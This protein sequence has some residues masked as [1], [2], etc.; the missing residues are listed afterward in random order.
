VNGVR[1]RPRDDHIDESVLQATRDH[2]AR[3][4]YEAMSVVAIAADAGTTRQAVYRRWPSKAELAAAAVASLADDQ[5]AP[6]TDDPFTDLVAE[7]ASFALG[8]SRPGGLSMIGT[9]LQDTTD[10]ELVRRFRRSVVA[11]R[12]TR[13]RAILDRALADGLLDADAD[14]AGAVPL[15][16]GSWYARALAGDPVPRGWAHRTASLVWRALGGTPPPLR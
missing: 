10:P 9:M 8:V 3:H 4:G 7:L 12:R 13:L 2:L 16:T 1:G 14:V 11:P 5:R 6:I 15:L